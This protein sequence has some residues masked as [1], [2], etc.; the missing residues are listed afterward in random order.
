MLL[1]K[2]FANAIFRRT[3]LGQTT[4]ITH[5]FLY[6]PGLTHR[7]VFHPMELIRGL[8]NLRPRHRGCAITVGAFDGIHRGHQAVLAH[9]RDKAGELGVPSVV[10]VF[11]PLPREYLRPLE[12]PPRVTNFRER[13]EA[14]AETGIDRLL[15][16]RFDETMRTSSAQ[17]FVQSIFVDALG[18]RYIALG[19]DFRFGNRR[20]GDFE[21]IRQLAETYGY[22][23][24]RTPTLE[25]HGERV[26]S[27]RVRKVLELGDFCTAEKLLGR[28]F[29]MK[30]K[31][32]YGRQ[33]GRQ[34]G[35][36]TANIRINRIRSPLSGVYAVRV[37]GPG[38]VQAAGVA[39]VGVRPTIEEG[40]TANLEVHLLGQ[41]CELYG[42]RLTVRFVSKLREEM[43]FDSLDAL[44]A[45]ISH[46]KQQALEVLAQ[47]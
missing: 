47:Q 19:D 11:E 33:L 1:A 22:E 41:Q 9:L 10:I 37:D 34:I 42:E 31:V 15:V 8:H 18:A 36:P 39:N 23:V 2:R 12:A 40:L 7:F 13:V 16:L 44:K 5:C 32:V 46:D 26:S 24:Q 38:L 30:G 25:L 6:T 35:T 27:T 4:P 45:A 29:T 20:E 21:Y 28:P 3:D 17:G 43:K 14:L